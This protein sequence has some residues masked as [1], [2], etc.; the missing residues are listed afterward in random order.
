MFDRHDVQDYI[1]RIGRSRG[2]QTIPIEER[3]W[4]RVGRQMPSKN[5]MTLFRCM[6]TTFAA[7]VMV[8]YDTLDVRAADDGR[9]PSF[10]PCER[11]SMVLYWSGHGVG[12]R[13]T[14]ALFG[15]SD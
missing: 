13:A 4:H 8:L 3:F 5:F 14:A 15:V 10:D 2:R 9:G 1:D 6:R 7:L 12:A 11:T